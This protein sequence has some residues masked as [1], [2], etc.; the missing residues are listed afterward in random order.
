[1]SSVTTTIVTASEITVAT[2]NVE[3]A[4]EKARRRFP[5]PCWTQEETLALIDAYRERWYALRRG[6]LRTADWD[7]VGAAVAN[8]CPGA[9]PEKTSAQCRHKMEKLRQR[10]RAEKQRALS[11]PFPAGRYFSSWFFFENMEAME[12]GT[13]P[14]ASVQKS[15]DSSDGSRSK[16]FID[17]NI[18]KL[19]LKAKNIPE[20]SPEL[21]SDKRSSSATKI[22]IQ[23]SSYLDMEVADKDEEDIPR[24]DDSTNRITRNQPMHQIPVQIPPLKSKSTKSGKV[25]NQFPASGEFHQQMPPP[26]F[27]IRKSGSDCIRSNPDKDFLM[28]FS[29]SNNNKFEDPSIETKYWSNL[30]HNLDSRS[31][32]NGLKRERHG[33]DEIV[34]SIKLLG[35]GFLKMEKEKMEMAREIES[36]R[37]DMEMKRNQML[38]ESQQQIVDAFLKGLFELK[39]CK[40]L[41]CDVTADSADP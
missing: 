38:V 35:E 26:G 7:A 17:Q 16:T 28:K 15:E 30:N 36:M 18:F 29:N 25:I 22:P 21:G 24:D 27:R 14:P 33:Y 37:M 20:S 41:K 2:D 4:T 40:K 1:M 3:K 5:P 23:Y 32:V 13:E 6:Y 19:K 10:Y 12:N 31:A 11:F 34:A 9:S 8:R 39:K